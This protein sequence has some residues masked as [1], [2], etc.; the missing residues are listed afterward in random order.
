ML[1]D[2]QDVKNYNIKWLRQQ[3]GV[4]SQEPVLFASSIAENIRFGHDGASIEDIEQAARQANAHDFISKLPKVRRTK[5]LF[6]RVKNSFDYF[7]QRKH[8]YFHFKFV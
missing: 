3:I 4:V 8:V 7:L 6:A 2:G 5:D 1:I